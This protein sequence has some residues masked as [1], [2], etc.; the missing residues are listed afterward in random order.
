MPKIS[1][2]QAVDVHWHMSP[3]HRDKGQAADEVVRT[4]DNL[5]PACEFAVSMAKE[6]DLD[7][8]LYPETGHALKLEDAQRIV[9]LWE[10]ASVPLEATE[11]EY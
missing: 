3:A 7:I 4:F 5:I 10:S 8:H 1:I 6:G 2:N 11:I 9:S